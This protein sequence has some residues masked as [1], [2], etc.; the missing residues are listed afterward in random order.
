MNNMTKSEA[1]LK[2]STSQFWQS[3]ASNAEASRGEYKFG[4]SG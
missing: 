1:E 4:R 2:I 3:R